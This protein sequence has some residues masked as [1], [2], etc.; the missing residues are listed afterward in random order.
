LRRCGADERDDGGSVDDAA[1]GL[2]VLAQREDS[3]LAAEPDAFDV[4][5]VGEVPDFLGRR[6]GVC[7]A[8]RKL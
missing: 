2:L 4:D 5:V 8:V 3:V 7:D 1:A 6:Y